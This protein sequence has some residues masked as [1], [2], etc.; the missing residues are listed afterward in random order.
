VAF[1]RSALLEVLDTLKVAEVDERICRAA[2]TIY[3]ALIEAELTAVI[4]AAPISAPRPGSPSAMGIAL[5]C[6]LPRPEIW[7]CGSPS[8]GPGRSSQLVRAAPAGRQALFAVVMEASLHGV[9]SRKVDDLVC[10]G[11]GADSGISKSE[12]SGICADLDAEVSAFRDRSLPD[13]TFP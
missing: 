3:Q 6:W 2:Q 8:C 1:D 9:S 12:V 10:P 13:Q 11:A 4:G 5:G 7:S